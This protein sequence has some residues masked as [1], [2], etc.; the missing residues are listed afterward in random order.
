MK[1]LRFLLLTIVL[2]A[3]ISCRQRSAHEVTPKI[4]RDFPSIRVPSMITAPDEAH[5]YVV[6]HYWD[7][8]CKT[9]GGQ[10]D[11]TAINSVAIG[12][13]EQA[14]VN[15]VYVLE[16]SAD[17]AETMIRT[18]GAKL[19]T[20]S[21]LAVVKIL[22]RYLYDPNSPLRNEELYLPV[23]EY[24]T[25]YPA[26]TSPEAYAK[27]ARL[28][29]LNRLGQVASDFRYTTKSG[30]TGTL[31]GIRAEYTLV[32]FSNPG[33]HDCKRVIDI[34]SA[35][36]LLTE[37]IASKRLAFLNY[38]PDENLSEWLAYMPIYPTSWIN[39]YDPDLE[40]RDTKYNIRAIPSIYLLDRDKRVIMKDVE[41]QVVINYLQQI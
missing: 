4:S 35:D 26:S 9:T 40:T 23:A 17:D 22:D 25:T 28:C 36:P 18:L 27:Y 15:Y 2:L 39:S 14:V 41:P 29:A 8:F 38:Y 5:R 33:C 7:H 3:A 19:D 34:F 37:L 11:S 10:T 12:A 31:H 1:F 30:H 32:F 13:V 20:A 24:M 16:S 21:F 6:E